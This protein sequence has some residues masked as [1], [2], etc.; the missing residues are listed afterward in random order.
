[1]EFRFVVGGA[2]EAFLTVEQENDLK[3]VV[4]LKLLIL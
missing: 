3:K 2:K 1:M 4:L